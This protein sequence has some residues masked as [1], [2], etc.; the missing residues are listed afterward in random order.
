MGGGVVT[1]WDAPSPWANFFEI[2]EELMARP[3][4]SK[5]KPREAPTDFQPPFSESAGENPVVAPAAKDPEE[6][7]PKKTKG[8]L[9]ANNDSQCVPKTRSTCGG[10]AHGPEYH[11]GSDADWCNLKKCRCQGWVD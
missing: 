10:C 11:Y 8:T 2:R 3:K 6:G 1:P 7:K 9:Y 4:G 5:N